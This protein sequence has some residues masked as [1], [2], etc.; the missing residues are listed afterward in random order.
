VFL[1]LWG[2][3]LMQNNKWHAVTCFIMFRLILIVINW[4]I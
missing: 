1:D 4:V 3:K 2:K